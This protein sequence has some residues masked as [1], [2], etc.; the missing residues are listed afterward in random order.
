MKY[1][2]SK[3]FRLLTILGQN[4]KGKLD[5]EKNFACEN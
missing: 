4:I 1:T 5:Y 2:L 3:I